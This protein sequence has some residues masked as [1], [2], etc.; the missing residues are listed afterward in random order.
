MEYRNTEITSHALKKKKK[1]RVCNEPA[2][3][4][5]M[6]PHTG[7]QRNVTGP[8]DRKRV[9]IKVCRVLMGAYK[10]LQIEFTK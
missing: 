7:L 4:S 2:G 5:A 10:Y 9:K 1:K 8:I 6:N 3:E